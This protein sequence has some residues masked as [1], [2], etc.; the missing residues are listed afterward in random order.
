M[1]GQAANLKCGLS[2]NDEV[3]EIT[4]PIDTVYIESN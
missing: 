3:Q 2:I 1:N 4:L